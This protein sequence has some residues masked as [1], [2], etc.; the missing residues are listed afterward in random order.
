M[1]VS[2]WCVCMSLS[3]RV[4]MFVCVCERVCVCEFECLCVLCLCVFAARTHAPETRVRQ[5]VCE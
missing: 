4:C 2:G 5:C 1:C 3:V